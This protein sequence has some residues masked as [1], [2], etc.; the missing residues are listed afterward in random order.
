MSCIRLPVKAIREGLV[1]PA[2][3]RTFYK[4]PG[5]SEFDPWFENRV[6][7][8]QMAKILGCTKTRLNIWVCEGRLPCDLV[9]GARWYQVD[10]V[11]KAAVDIKL[12]LRVLRETDEPPS[13]ADDAR[14][15]WD[16]LGNRPWNIRRAPSGRA[17]FWYLLAR[18]HDS[19]RFRLSKVFLDLAAM[20]LGRSS[21]RV[22]AIMPAVGEAANEPEARPLTE[23]EKVKATLDLSR[24]EAPI[25]VETDY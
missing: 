11:L 8:H 21:A 15:A 4:P 24:V 3:V 16:A 5:K 12:P 9:D 6:T 25:A 22:G 10:V 18:K 23:A 1:P 19:E 2:E 14:W 7:A 20:E 17:W 13:F